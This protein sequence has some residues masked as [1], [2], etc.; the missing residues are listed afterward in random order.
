M[1]KT[2]YLPTEAVLDINYTMTMPM[3]QV[4][5]GSFDTLS[6]CMETYLGIPRETNLSDE[7]NEA[8]MR[9][10]IKN[11]KAVIKNP[12]DKFVRSEL[13]WASAMAENGILKLGKITDFHCHMLEHQLGAYTNCNH[14]QGLA[15]IHPVLYKHIYKEAAAQFAKLAKNVWGID[16]NGKTDEQTALEGINALA[17]FIKEMGLPTK[18]SDMGIIDT[19]YEDIAKSTII[20]GGFCKKLNSDELL[21]ILEE[22]K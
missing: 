13:I 21:E 1:A 15:V 16:G 22:C 4:I 6:H 2:Y 20:T 17:E 14:G 11:M 9:N 8:V 7:I 18:F 19:N 3:K 12:D 10:V 5:S